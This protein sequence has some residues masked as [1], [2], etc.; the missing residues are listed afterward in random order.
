MINNIFTLV[1]ASLIFTASC[2]ANSVSHESSKIG[3]LE[4]ICE[5]HKVN[6]VCFYETS[7]DFDHGNNPIF[8]DYRYLEN[9]YRNYRKSFDQLLYELYRPILRERKFKGFWGQYV[10]LTFSLDTREFVVENLAVNYEEAESHSRKSNAMVLNIANWD[11]VKRKDYK[12]KK[13]ESTLSNGQ[14]KLRPSFLAKLDEMSDGINGHEVQLEKNLTISVDVEG[15]LLA[16]IKES[17]KAFLDE[18][19]EE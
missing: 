13:E 11:I 6:N 12:I 18:R 15:D 1:F 7:F 16:F 5:N 9:D 4:L 14:K 10:S 2:L 19:V 17:F 3:L 8:R